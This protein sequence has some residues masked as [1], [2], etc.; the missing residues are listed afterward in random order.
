MI[1]KYIEYKLLY[2]HEMGYKYVYIYI[3]NFCKCNVHVHVHCTCSITVY[4]FY[5]NVSLFLGG[6]KRYCRAKVQG[7]V[8]H[9]KKL[10]QR[11]CK[12]AKTTSNQ[13][14]ICD[15]TDA[16]L[17]AAVAGTVPI[18]NSM[19]EIALKGRKHGATRQRYHMTP[20]GQVVSAVRK[21][22]GN[23]AAADFGKLLMS[24]ISKDAFLRAEVVLGSCRIASMRQFHHSNE[25]RQKI[26]F[27]SIAVHSFSMNLNWFEHLSIELEEF[28]FSCNACKALITRYYIS[29]STSETSCTRCSFPR[30][31]GVRVREGL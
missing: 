20:R 5:F 27:P 3:W 23:I 28:M 11:R 12:R 15:I 30:Q 29:T 7:T 2:M 21:T 18:T 13:L 16:Q 22:L 1:Q 24:D 9:T 25:A 19:F 8:R 26:G 10:E 31:I 14:A 17:A 4:V 6:W